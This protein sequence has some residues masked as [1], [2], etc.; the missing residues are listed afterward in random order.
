MLNYQNRPV[1]N[2]ST[3]KK[4]SDINESNPSLKAGMG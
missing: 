1:I 2:V 3:V 4:I